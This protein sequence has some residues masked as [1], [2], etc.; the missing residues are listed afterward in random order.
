MTTATA[1]K[2]TSLV[3][4][5]PSREAWLDAR[6]QGIGSSEAA[7][8]LGVSPFMTPYTLY[9]EKLGLL[10]PKA[11]TRAMKI[12]LLLQDDIIELYVEDT[13]RLVIAEPPNSILVHP[14]HEWLIASLDGRHLP[15][16]HNGRRYEGEGVLEA[17]SAHFMK[18]DEWTDEPPPAYQVQLQHQ[19]VVKDVRWG[20]IAVLVGYDLLW[21]VMERDEAFAGYLVEKERAFMDRL[22]R[23]DE[24]LADGSEE[25]RD[26]LKRLYPKDVG[27]SVVLPPGASD[28]DADYLLGH[29]QEKQGKKLKEEASNRLRQAIGEASYGLMPGGVIW[30]NKLVQVKAEE[31]P[32]GA[33]E[34][35]KL[36]RSLKKGA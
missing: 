32:R 2:P 16:Q 18:R 15:F 3:R 13:N 30:S 1:T 35:R 17:K 6:L 7:A 25:T 21:M 23:R 12:G 27:T 26:L 24:P 22:E 10:P 36:N 19:M 9:Q 4:T 31:Q 8:I 5:F 28:W 34:Y 29:E 33:H 11:T 14:T 20:V